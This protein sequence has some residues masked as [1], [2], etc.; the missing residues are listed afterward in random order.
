MT[1][2]LE[3]SFVA[4]GGGY[5]FSAD[6][7]NVANGATGAVAAIPEPETYLLMLA[8]LGVLGF[9]ARRRRQD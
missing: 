5:F 4:N 6:L 2:L 8:G 7:L 9:A 1:G 3:S